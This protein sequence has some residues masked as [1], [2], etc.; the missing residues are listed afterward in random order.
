VR[1]IRYRTEG[2]IGTRAWKTSQGFRAQ[3]QDGAEIEKVNQVI[4]AASPEDVDA[5]GA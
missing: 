2:S 3:G 1:G 4:G 5:N